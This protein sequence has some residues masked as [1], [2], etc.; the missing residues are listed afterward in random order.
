MHCE[1]ELCHLGL[2]GSTRF[3]IWFSQPSQENSQSDWLNPKIIGNCNTLAYT[4][5]GGWFSSWRPLNSLYWK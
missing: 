3:S 1:H 2:Q 5:I 4:N